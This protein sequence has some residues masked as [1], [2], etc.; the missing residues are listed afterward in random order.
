[1][2]RIAIA[3]AIAGALALPAGA[4]AAQPA[5]SPYVVILDDAVPN[6]D[7]AID[8]LRA[9]VG[10]TPRFRY[11][12]ALNGFAARLSAGQVAALR[13]EPAVAFVEPDVAISAAG[14]TPLAAGEVSP[15]GVRRIRAA[16]T[17]TAHDASGTSVAVL[18]TGVDLANPDLDAVTGVN[19]VKAGAAAQDDNGHG[20]HVAGIVAARNVGSG[21]VGVAPGTRIYAVKVLGPRATGTLSQF[22]CG[23][24]W[25]TA[26]AEALKIR[27]ANMSIT[28]SG[29]SDGDCGNTN[30]DSEHKAICAAVAAGVTFAVS[31]GNAGTDFARSI[32]AAYPEVLTVT[33]MTD[34]DGLPGAIGSA[35]SCKKGEADDRAAAYSNY[36]VGPAAAAHTIAAPGTCV[37]ATKLGGGTAT[38]YGT[39]QAAPHVSGAAALCMGSSG[40]P[41]PCAGLSPAGVIARVRADASAA[42]T[43]PNG[44]LGD[45]L[46]PLAGKTFGPLVSVGG[47]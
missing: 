38:Y 14:Q 46:R 15:A 22:L 23:I 11:R 2:R 6:A 10:F 31:A 40:Q 13:A 33:A 24:N 8:G 30:A 44:F 39:S 26:N 41:G 27:V 45:P 32:P 3:V 12:S 4:A 47:Y 43:L 19:C 35:V 29:S 42:A 16:T 5:T 9:A 25:V 28:G 34:T 7:A 1:M 37:V 21:V 17:T 20:T 36:A 18:D